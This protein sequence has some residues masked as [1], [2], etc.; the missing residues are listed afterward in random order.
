VTLSCGK[1]QPSDSPTTPTTG[2]IATIEG[3]VTV[4]GTG[5]PLANV[6]VS[7]GGQRTTTAA[8]GDYWMHVPDGILDVR[9]ERQGYVP[10]MERLAIS[11]ARTVDIA[12]APS[13]VTTASGS[14]LFTH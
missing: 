6:A 12:L 8:N 4:A 7:A 2:T 10:Y 9:A 14:A 5:N 11:G 13:R 3:T 1:E